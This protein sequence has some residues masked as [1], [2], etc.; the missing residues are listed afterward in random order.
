MG[1]F[2]GVHLHHVIYNS[3]VA[4][5]TDC[6]ACWLEQHT[7]SVLS[8]RYVAWG[9]IGYTYH[10]TPEWI[11]IQRLCDVRSDGSIYILVFACVS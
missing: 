9:N 10:S 2:V 4:G 1:K 8:I 6:Q 3:H 11:I 7:H 5:M